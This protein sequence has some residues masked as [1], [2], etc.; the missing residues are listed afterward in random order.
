MLVEKMLVEKMLVE[1][2]L[3]EKEGKEIFFI[4]MFHI[5]AIDDVEQG[6]DKHQPV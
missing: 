4:S 6:V 1:K 2:M 3:V 5:L